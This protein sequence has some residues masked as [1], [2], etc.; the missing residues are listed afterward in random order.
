MGSKLLRHAALIFYFGHHPRLG[1]CK[2]FKCS[3]MPKCTSYIDGQ[4]GETFNSF[5]NVLHCTA[6]H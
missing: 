6:L 3:S 5:L 4:Q 2:T 1:Q